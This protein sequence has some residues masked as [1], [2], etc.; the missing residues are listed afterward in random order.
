MKVRIIAPEYQ[1]P[2]RKTKLRAGDEAVLNDNEA[3]KLIRWGYAVEAPKP[4]NRNQ[5]KPTEVSAEV[6]EA[7]VA[8]GEKEN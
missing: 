7:A 1:S 5:T 4:K 3:R 8:D 6:T 2:E